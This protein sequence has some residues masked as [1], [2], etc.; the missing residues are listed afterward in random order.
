MPII[1]K[2][3]TVSFD[4]PLWLFDGSLIAPV[5]DNMFS[6]Y[7]L[8]RMWPPGQKH[9]Y[10]PLYMMIMY[11]TLYKTYISKYSRQHA[12]HKAQSVHSTASKVQ[13]GT[14]A[15][16]FTDYWILPVQI[17]SITIL[18][19]SSTLLC[20]SCTGT[21]QWTYNLKHRTLTTWHKEWTIDLNPARLESSS[22][23][24]YFDTFAVGSSNWK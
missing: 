20:H 22:Q 8:H 1:S 2:Q 11:S 7:Q 3:A 4:V 10:S 18:H 14:V 16:H 13:Y 23:T 17:R 24:V 19:E 5:H 21:S 9:H 12:V 6:G 15:S